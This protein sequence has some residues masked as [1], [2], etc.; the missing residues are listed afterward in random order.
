MWR[1]FPQFRDFSRWFGDFCSFFGIF[2][3]IPW[4]R[5]WCSLFCSIC[6]FSASLSPT[7]SSLVCFSCWPPSLMVPVYVCGVSF[8]LWRWSCVF[9]LSSC[10]VWGKLLLSLFWCGCCAFFPGAPVV[11]RSVSCN[12]L[13]FSG[14]TPRWQR[15]AGLLLQWTFI[16]GLAVS[17]YATWFS[18][19]CQR[20]SSFHCFPLAGAANFLAPVCWSTPAVVPCCWV[21]GVFAASL[22]FLPCAVL[23]LRGL[24]LAQLTLQQVPLAI[25][26]SPG[27]CSS[28]SLVK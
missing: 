1:F 5:F 10:W 17:W 12:W 27:V 23:F 25:F 18:T 28:A 11:F 3:S 15:L 14:S 8:F 13:P 19:L 2:A 7:V 6:L 24:Q 9:F 4:L 20:S 21:G 16:V 22:G 26:R